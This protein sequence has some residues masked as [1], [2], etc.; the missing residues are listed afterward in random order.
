MRGDMMESCEF[1]Q[2]L[3]YHEKLISFTDENGYEHYVCL[4]CAT[5]IAEALKE[6][7]N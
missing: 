5:K 1:C 3:N 2:V 7:E 6:E 4:R